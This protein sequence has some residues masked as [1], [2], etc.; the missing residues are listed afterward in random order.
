MS[1]V[2]SLTPAALIDRCQSHYHIEAVRT[3]IRHY[4]HMRSNQDLYLCLGVQA[5]TY[6]LGLELDRFV[7]LLCLGYIGAEFISHCRS[8]YVLHSFPK[9]SFQSIEKTA[10][11]IREH[12]LKEEKNVQKSVQG[13]EK[14][15]HKSKTRLRQIV[16]E[17]IPDAKKRIESMKEEMD[18]ETLK[19]HAVNEKIATLNKSISESKA[20]L[21]DNRSEM[22]PLLQR[23]CKERLETVSRSRQGPLP[24]SHSPIIEVAQQ[25]EAQKNLRKSIQENLAKKSRSKQMF[26]RHFANRKALKTAYKKIF[27]QSRAAIKTHSTLRKKLGNNLMY[28][29]SEVDPNIDS[30]KKKLRRDLK[31]ESVYLRKYN[32]FYAALLPT[33]MKMFFETYVGISAE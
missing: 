6:Y 18:E 17:E 16:D 26:E 30:L 25:L 8:Y 24:L 9:E 14:R 31:N 2:P 22:A 11:K 7:A 10:A 3:H 19:L 5:V 21:V 1:G 33:F 23:D 4:M 28:P 20:L 29:L 13:E 12:L 15:F 27:K 32:Y